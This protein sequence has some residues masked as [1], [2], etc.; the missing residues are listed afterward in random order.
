MNQ[1]DRLALRFFDLG[2]VVR[3]DF[4]YADGAT[5]PLYMNFR[6]VL[7]YPDLL[8]QLTKQFWKLTKALAF[9]H[10]C[11][12]PYAAIPWATTLGVL[13]D[14]SV[15]LKRKGVV[16]TGDRQTVEGVFRKGDICLVLDDLINSGSS[17]LETIESLEA[18]GLKVTD[19]ATIVDRRRGGS[20][21]LKRRGY[22]VHTLYTIPELVRIHRQSPRRNVKVSARMRT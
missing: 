17:I 4:R 6:S 18:E 15:I 10:V 20:A 11:G 21:A 12:V 13:H 2:L 9:S 16:S 22:R 3:G 1:K 5:T 7:A 8:G 19:V 14:K